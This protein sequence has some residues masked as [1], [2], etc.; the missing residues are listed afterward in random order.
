LLSRLWSN[1]GD[2]WNVLTLSDFKYALRLIAKSPGFTLLTVLV[3]AGGLG[4]SLYTFAALNTIVYRDLPIADGGMVRRVGVGRWPNFEPLD[5]YELSVL[6]AQANGLVAL[7]PYRTTRTLIGDTVAPLNARAIEADWGIFDFT[8]TR[9]LLGRGFVQQDSRIGAERVAVLGHD[10][11]RSAF[12]ADPDV[13]GS[14]LRINGQSTRIVGVMPEGY[15]FPVNAEVWLPLDQSVLSPAAPT[16]ERLDAYARIRADMPVTAIESELTTIVQRLRAEYAPDDDPAR[17]KVS[18]VTFQAVSFGIFGDVV[19]GVLNLLALSILLLAAVNVGNLLLARTNRR[20]R[21]VGVRVALGAPRARLIA[22]VVLESVLLCALG[23]AAAIWLAARG[24][25]ATHGFMRSLLG[26]HMPFWW[27]WQLDRAVL[28]TAGLVLVLT[29]FVVSVLPAISVSRADPNLLLREGARGGGLHMGRVSRALVTLQVA[30]LSALMLVGSVATVIAGRVASFD[31]GMNIDDVLMMTVRP[32][33]R[34]SSDAQRAVYERVLEE[35]RASPDIDAAAIMA[36]EPAARF[37]VGGAEYPSL[38]DYAG[39]WRV[40][41]SATLVP[42]GPTLIE[43]RAFDSRDTPTSLPTAIVS[44]SLARAYWPNA[45]PLGHT[46]EVSTGEDGMERRVVVGVMADVAFDPV[47][48]TPVGKLAIYFP[49]SQ[50]VL[51]ATRIIARHNGNEARAR[52]AMYQAVKRVDP[53]SVPGEIQ[54]YK[55]AIDQITLFG[56]TIMKLFAGCGVFAVLIAITG[57][58]GMSANGVVLRRHEI[59]LRRALGASDGRVLGIFVGQGARQLAAGLIFSGVLSAVVLAAVS[60]G[61]S[62]DGATLALLGLAVL[63]AVSCTVLLSIYLSVR[64]VLK[65]EPSS[66]LRLA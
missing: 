52:S 10:I 36:E 18:V 49:S 29:V 62:L 33:A 21:E 60:Q 39:A 47:G 58:Y 3:L 13:V 20:I 48:M 15:R 63:V 1:P 6:R 64:G 9:P 28:A 56:R 61:F 14:L 66:V 23:G 34:D 46:I 19:F 22:Q 25:A 43:G 30:L 57:I 59:G 54:T 41:L 26:P 5:A 53:G 32:A 44:Q 55:E 17:E 27:V 2:A 38:D 16:G 12:A 24:L 7:G 65:L 45:S 4:I 42:I 50:L 31:F 51:P 35:M 40:V 8:G 11:W 37:S